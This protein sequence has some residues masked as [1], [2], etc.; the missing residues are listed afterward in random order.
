MQLLSRALSLHWCASSAVMVGLLGVHTIVQER[1]RQHSQK[2]LSTSKMS[3]TYW[4]EHIASFTGTV[5][6]VMEDAPK[7]ARV[8]RYTKDAAGEFEKILASWMTTHALEQST[9]ISG[10]SADL[11][12]AAIFDAMEEGLGQ[13]DIGR[14]ISQTFQGNIS[15]HRAVMTART[16][17]HAAS[18][19]ASLEVAK[20]MDLP[21]RL[22]EWVAV[23]DGRTRRDHRTANG[24]RVPMDGKFQVGNAKL[25]YPGDPSGPASEVINCRC[26]LVYP[27]AI[28]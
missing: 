26:V 4:Q 14:A 8:R 11:V 22:K 20:G 2:Q 15:D 13:Q 18:Q 10:T 1:N 17:T 21:G 28:A 25:D 27:R 6:S 7:T 5:A 16:E 3:R 12:S 24:Q 23:E 9:L 19:N